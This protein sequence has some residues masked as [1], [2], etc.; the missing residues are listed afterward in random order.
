MFILTAHNPLTAVVDWL[1]DHGLKASYRD[2]LPEFWS[3]RGILLVT[4]IKLPAAV[5]IDDRS[6]RFTSWSQ[7]LN[8]LPAAMTQETSPQAASRRRIYG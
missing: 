5:Y 7:V 2:E 6:I 4:N 8:E 1:E 3:R